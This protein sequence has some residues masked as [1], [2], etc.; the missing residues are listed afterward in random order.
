VATLLVEQIFTLAQLAPQLSTLLPLVSQPSSA[1]PVAGVLQSRLGL[2]QTGAQT[3]L[4][5]TR[6]WTVAPPAQM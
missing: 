6:V 4:S 3:P 1:V 5:H 2:L